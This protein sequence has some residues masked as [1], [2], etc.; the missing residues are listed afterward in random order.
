MGIKANASAASQ[1]GFVA[2]IKK[3]ANIVNPVPSFKE[4]ANQAIRNS[5]NNRLNKTKKAEE[6][7][8]KNA[9]KTIN[10]ANPKVVKSFKN[11]RMSDGTK[12]GEEM[13]GTT[14]GVAAYGNSLEE[15]IDQLTEAVKSLEDGSNTALGIRSAAS[16]KDYAYGLL[17]GLKG[18]YSPSGR[19]AGENL[20]RYGTTL[21]IYAGTAIGAR[22]LNG[23]SLTRNAD[24]SKDIVGIPFI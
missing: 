14:Q 20:L 17:G 18:Y 19:S 22:E 5:L 3:A 4:G 12:L 13:W 21:G 6:L 8:K 24:G 10:R 7:F 1:K 9:G 16:V 15:K 11:T 2:G 23:G